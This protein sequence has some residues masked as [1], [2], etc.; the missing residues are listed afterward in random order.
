MFAAGLSDQRQANIG[1]AAKLST[2]LGKAVA[3][4]VIEILKGEI[5]DAGGGTAPLDLVGPLCPGGQFRQ[6]GVVALF[7]E[8]VEVGD[9]LNLG[10]SASSL[11]TNAAIIDGLVATLKNDRISGG[12]CCTLCQPNLKKVLDVIDCCFN[13]WVRNGMLN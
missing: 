13:S 2:D 8:V 4:K 11:P 7:P 6:E 3:W 1:K 9:N 5:R 12:H 10:I